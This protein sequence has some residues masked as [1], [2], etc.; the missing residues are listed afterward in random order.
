[1][2]HYSSPGIYVEEVSGGTRPIEAVGT[3][4]AGFVGT[5]PDPDARR[6]EALARKI[7][8]IA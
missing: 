3:S 8:R 1:M 2:P 6:D 5:A 4:T 7:L